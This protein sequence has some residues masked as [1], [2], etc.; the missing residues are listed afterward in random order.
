M[1]S[2]FPPP[3]KPGSPHGCRQALYFRL[4][5]GYG[6]SAMVGFLQ[7]KISK[8]KRCNTEVRWAQKL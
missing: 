5:A 1:A 3:R 7:G 8:R 4:Q 6:F 2:A